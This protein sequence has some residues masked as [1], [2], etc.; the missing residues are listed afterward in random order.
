MA[1]CVVVPMG[2]GCANITGVRA[3]DRN[4]MTFAVTSKGVP[5]N[6][7]GMA[8]SAQAKTRSTD[9]TPMITAVITVTDAAAGSGEMRWPGDEVRIALNGKPKWEG[10]WDLQIDDGIEDPVTVAYGSFK[11]EMDVTR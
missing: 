1:T 4:L 2:P 5:V 10:V 9:E 3:G 7:A 6:L 8:L 11:A